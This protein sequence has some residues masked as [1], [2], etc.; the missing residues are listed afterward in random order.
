ML[1]SRLL[2]V[3]LLIAV[4]AAQVAAQNFTGKTPDT[5]QFA[6]SAQLNSSASP[7]LPLLSPNLQTEQGSE[8]PLDRIH[9]GE[10][11]PQLSRFGVRDESKPDLLIPGFPVPHFL[12]SNPDRQP[13][14]DNLCYSMR[15]YKVARDDSHSDS[16]H[17]AGYSTCQ[18]AARFHTRSIEL[19][20]SPPAP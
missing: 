2:P 8:N 12:S 11:S 15:S 1:I 18:P 17:A 13:S 16:T 10:Y 20:N 14:D 9:V 5:I 3:S 7:D 4:C 19:R 6:D